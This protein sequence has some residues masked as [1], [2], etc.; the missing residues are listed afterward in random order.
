MRRNRK[1]KGGD[2]F[3]PRTANLPVEI[4]NYVKDHIFVGI[5]A[6]V[7]MAEPVGGVSVD[8]DISC[9]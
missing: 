5:V 4:L 1:Y 7:V 6:V 8:L 2:S 3:S 9:P